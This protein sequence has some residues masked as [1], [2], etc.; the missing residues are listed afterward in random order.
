M[1]EVKENT[2]AE[3]SAV[4]T[5]EKESAKRRYETVFI[6]LTSSTE[7][8]NAFVAVNGKAY[9]IPKGVNTDVPAEVAYELRRSVKAC[10]K[11]FDYIKA[12]AKK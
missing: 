3:K 9:Q 10:K 4:K 2:T 11:Q 12:N 1:A 5:A 7:E 8:N 6:P